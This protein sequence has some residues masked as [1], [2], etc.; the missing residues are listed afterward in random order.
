MYIHTYKD[1]LCKTLT[2]HNHPILQGKQN[3]TVFTFI[4]SIIYIYTQTHLSLSLPPSVCVL[5]FCSVSSFFSLLKKR[6][7]VL[8]KGSE[9]CTLLS[10]PSLIHHSFFHAESPKEK[11]RSE[12]G[13]V[14]F[15][16]TF[17]PK[18]LFCSS[19]NNLE[20]TMHVLIESWL[21]LFQLL[22][23]EETFKIGNGIDVL[24]T[25]RMPISTIGTKWACHLVCD[26]FLR[27]R[28][29]ILL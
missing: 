16:A 27:R 25:T 6:F 5:N 23:I 4:F 12:I 2:V 8:E 29:T 18:I 7:S 19:K 11:S 21:L 3:S 28:V 24:S 13:I 9:Q 15:S 20:A 14:N 22:K 17:F 10:F 26:Y 1:S